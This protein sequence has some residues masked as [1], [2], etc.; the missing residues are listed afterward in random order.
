MQLAGTGDGKLVFL[1]QLVHAQDGDD[2]LQLLIALQ[3][4][5]H[6]AGHAVMLLAHDIGF[7]NTGGGSQR[8]HG[9]VDA[10]LHDLTAQDGGGVQME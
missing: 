8:I 5:L 6:L 7:Q 4:G 9:G 10:L 1:A 3:G 2:V